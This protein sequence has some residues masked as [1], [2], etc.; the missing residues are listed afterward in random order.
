MQAMDKVKFYISSAYFNKTECFCFNQQPLEG[1]GEADM[2]L[3]FVI[4]QE[5]PRDITTI[6]LSYTL[7]DVTPKL[8]ALN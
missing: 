8:A 3:Q 4:D 7:F 6:T 5:L 1:G 2:P